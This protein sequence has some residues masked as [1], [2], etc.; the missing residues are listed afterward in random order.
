MKKV[1]LFMLMACC[2]AFAGCASKDA[3]VNAFIAENSAVIK[4]MTDK[5][6]ANPTAAGIDDAQKAFDAKKGDLK[7]KWDAIKEARGAQVSADVQK[8]LNDSMQ[9]DMKTLTEVSSKN[10]MKL[11][12]SEGAMPKFQK[13]MQ[14]YGDTFK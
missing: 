12:T 11:A 9:S 6:D 7:S 5:I 3:E 10:A 4:E 1:T 13:L 14:D 8:K 2:L